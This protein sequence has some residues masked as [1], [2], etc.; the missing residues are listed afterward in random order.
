MHD[1]YGRGKSQSLLKRLFPRATRRLANDDWDDI[2][3]LQASFDEVR[4]ALRV[5][6]YLGKYGWIVVVVML[7]VPI[8]L[9]WHL[10]VRGILAGALLS[11]AVFCAWR[12]GR[13]MYTNACIH[14]GGTSGFYEAQRFL[15]R[16]SKSGIELHQITREIATYRVGRFVYS[17]LG[18][19]HLSWRLYA[20]AVLLLLALFWSPLVG[21]ALLSFL[22]AYILFA[23]TDSHMPIA[24]YLGPSSLGAIKLFWR[25]RNETGIP[26][27][28]LLKDPL[29]VPAQLQGSV[30]EQLD[31][32]L[33]QIYSNPWS[34]RHDSNA[35]WLTIVRDFVDTS[36]IIVI[37][38]ANVPAVLKELDILRVSHPLA[39]IVAVVEDPLL[40]ELVPDELKP[41][42]MSEAEA[43]GFLM[44]IGTAPRTFLPF[45]RD[46]L[47]LFPAS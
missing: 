26:W 30:Q 10:G 19:P 41:A 47:R 28:S 43:M 29:E 22:L 27:A 5:D 1:P 2:E 46:R 4:G 20:L 39:R 14:P 21:T 7:L 34:L 16:H 11:A 44:R 36:I 31:M 45:L 35:D 33:V 3:S 6:M 17:D 24:L 8:L 9:G 38:V 37:K 42:I 13:A 12:A 18:P 15:E 32:M 23:F 25:I 40:L